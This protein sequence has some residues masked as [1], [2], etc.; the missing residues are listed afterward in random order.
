MR[1][2]P[3]AIIVLT[4][5]YYF[6]FLAL[7]ALNIPLQDDIYDVLQFVL[8]I[9]VTESWST[10]L[11]LLLQQHNDHRTGASRLIFYGVYWLEGE[12]NFRTL[13]FI[14]SLA[15][16]MILGLLY[17]VVRKLPYPYLLLLPSVFILFQIRSYGITLWSMAAFAY[18]YVFLYGF[19]CIFVLHNVSRLKLVMAAILA[20]LATFTLASGQMI[21]L[22]GLVSLLH[23][24]LVLR[25]TS[26]RFVLVWLLCAIPVLV[27][28]NYGLD[29]PLSPGLILS[30]ILAAPLH[31][32]HYF[33][34]LLGSGVSES[35]VFTA[36]AAGVV[37]LSSVVLISARSFTESDVR[38][39]LCCWYIVATVLAMVMGRAYFTEVQYALTSRYSFPSVLMMCTLWVLFAYKLKLHQPYILGFAAL[40][41]CL[42]T[43]N[44]Y[45][46]YSPLLQPHMEARVNWYN[47]EIYPLWGSPKGEPRMIVNE[48]ILQGI[49]RP[50]ARPYPVPDIQL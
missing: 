19:A 16:P 26:I 40:L 15:L 34:A 18:F 22:L 13:I 20:S 25:Q 27:L 11:E 8:N 4:A 12:V 10:I 49:Y 37:A 6:R 31:H 3:L 1:Y 32:L 29:T 28:W 30:N 38:L 48:A 33:L 17:I 14:S 5:A 36:T 23:Q 46:V 43:V 50:P 47:K 41:A 39:E 21:W 2:L 9:N 45:S 42:Y 44:S 7:Y 35:S 24:V